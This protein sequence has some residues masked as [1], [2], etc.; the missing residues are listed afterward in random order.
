M[1]G[2]FLGGICPGCFFPG[3]IFQD[4]KSFDSS[5]LYLPEGH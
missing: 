1:G 2:N 3:D 4:T 5:N